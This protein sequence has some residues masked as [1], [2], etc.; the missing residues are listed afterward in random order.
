MRWQGDQKGSCNAIGPLLGSW[1]NTFNA[2]G[3][4]KISNTRFRRILTVAIGCASFADRAITCLFAG[5]HLLIEDMPGMGKTTLA[6][7]SYTH[8]TLPTSDLV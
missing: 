7:V 2:E 6:P 8:L 1:G 5:G 3:W 4:I